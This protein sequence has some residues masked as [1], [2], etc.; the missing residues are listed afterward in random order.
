MPPTALAA[1]GGEAHGF[2][3]AA[4][5]LMF[6]TLETSQRLTSPLKAGAL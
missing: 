3:P 2:E 5:Q 1:H 6:V 4:Y